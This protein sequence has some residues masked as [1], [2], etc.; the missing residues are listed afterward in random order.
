[1]AGGHPEQVA[2]PH[3]LE[4]LARLARRVL[5]E[6][7]EDGVAQAQLPI[8][9]RQADGGGGEAL[10]QRV[11]R[12]RRL[13]RI[14]RPPSLHDDLAVADDHHAVHP[15]DRLVE[16]V[17]ELTEVGR[18]DTLRLGGAPREAG[19]ARLGGQRD[20]AL[21]EQQAEESER[22]HEVAPALNP[23]TGARNPGYRGTTLPSTP[24]GR[25][26]PPSPRRFGRVLSKTVDR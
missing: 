2:D 24:V 7:L 25:A 1:M 22:L 10:A 19:E 14:G 21:P 23:R 16:G 5:G 4:V 11:E 12:L 20:R 18:R 9:D 13:G 15:L 3:R 6:E 26:P 8:G 17:D